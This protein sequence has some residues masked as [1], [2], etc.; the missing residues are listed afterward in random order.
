MVKDNY[1]LIEC[2]ETL[3]SYLGEEKEKIN[4][5]SASSAI[6]EEEPAAEAA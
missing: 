4:F 3:N 2:Q 1:N 6:N 5:M